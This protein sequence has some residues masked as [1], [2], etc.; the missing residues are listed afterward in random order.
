MTPESS[1]RQ[2]VAI[3]GSGVAGATAA[4]TLRSEGFD[5]RVVLI[6]DEPD[7]P[8][9]RP[10]L[11]KDV[12]R[13]SMPQERTRLKPPQTWQ[14]QDIELL[15]GTTVT[16]VD[17]GAQTL[18]LG[19]RGELCYD[20]LLLATGG[21]A[22]RLPQTAPLAGVYTLR[23]LADVPAPRAAL[24]PGSS[25]LVI[26]AGL[27]GAEVAASARA[28]ECSV[29]MLESEHT[30]LSRLL[31]PAISRVYADLHREQGVDLFT[32]VDVRRLERVDLGLLA[33]DAHDNHWLADTVVV[34]IGMVPRTELAE[35]AGIEVDN[36]IV[37][38][39]FFQ[40]SAP[41]VYAAGDVANQPNLVLGG[42]HRVEHW[43]SAQEQGAAAAKSMVGDRTPFARVPWCWSDQ[44]GVNL[45]VTGW[46]VAGDNVT[47]RGDLDALDFT[48]IF[49]RQG[50]LVGAVG[51]NRAAEVRALRKFVTEAP[52]AAAGVL[53]DPGTDLATIDPATLSTVV[54]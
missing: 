28:M 1:T 12:L 4:L 13:G 38:D 51:V 6:G 52:Y 27:I 33:S 40:T 41:G 7:E 26:G 31:P 45:Q 29:M 16:R 9:R 18:D 32:G 54:T 22:R 19:D 5:G 36:G 17:V 8:Y 15:T 23:S 25:V 46:P 10:P 48:A 34:A 47:V 30:P 43:Q 37:V 53:A 3:V 20:K 35:Q 14:Q 2:S 11:S 24:T 42:R 44:Y 50:R 39:E 49:H 21:R